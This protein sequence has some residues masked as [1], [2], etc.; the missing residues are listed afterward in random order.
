MVVKPLEI[1]HHIDGDRKRG[2]AIP[3]C[4]LFHCNKI[5]GLVGDKAFPVQI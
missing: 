3:D 4:L 5:C 2:T 1:V